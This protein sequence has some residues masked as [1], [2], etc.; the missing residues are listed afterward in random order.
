MSSIC[1][2]ELGTHSTSCTV[3]TKDLSSFSVITTTNNISDMR[4]ILEGKPQLMQ[5]RTTFES[6]C[7]IL[8]GMG[9]CFD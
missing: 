3:S 4:N 9:E 6:N 5:D 7:S 2:C 1:A 8:T